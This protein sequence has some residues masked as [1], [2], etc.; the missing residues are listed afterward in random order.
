MIKGGIKGGFFGLEGYHFMRIIFSIIIVIW[1]S[2]FLEYWTR[3]ETMFAA[4]FNG[5]D[6][7]TR[8]YDTKGGRYGTGGKGLD[9][10]RRLGFKGRFM[11][12]IANSNYNSIFHSKM[13]RRCIQI[14]SFVVSFLLLCVSCALTCAI[15]YFKFKAYERFKDNLGMIRKNLLTLLPPIINFACAKTMIK[16]HQKIAIKFTYKENYETVEEF[17]RVLIFKTYI[18]NFLNLFNSIFIILF[19]K[20]SFEDFFGQCLPFNP[21]IEAT[22]GG[23]LRLLENVASGFTRILTFGID[24]R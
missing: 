4:R 12:D 5:D 17:E 1:T 24:T 6:L 15:L 9:Q 22:V 21:A 11:R 3:R 8:S 23:K 18:F 13:S 10:R 2:S 7:N 14:L 16:I 20:P 19:V